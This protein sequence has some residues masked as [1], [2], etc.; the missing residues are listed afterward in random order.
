MRKRED[1]WFTLASGRNFY[2]FN[3]QVDH[4]FI[5]DIA[6]ALSHLCRYN[7]HCRKFYS[8]AEH[9]VHCSYHVAEGHELAALMHDA[10]EAYVG[11]LIRPIKV[12]MPDFEEMEEQVWQ[13]IATRFGLPQELPK[14]VKTVDNVLLVTEARDLL[15]DGADLM[16]KWGLPHTP[17]EDLD[18]ARNGRLPWGPEE[19]ERQFLARF[20]ELYER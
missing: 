10:T 19:A 11:D 4:I 16:K 1:S 8:V 2:P 7:G 9:S 6:L 17:I 14:E 15:P 20:Q 3:P 18:I 12:Y 13:A 5:E